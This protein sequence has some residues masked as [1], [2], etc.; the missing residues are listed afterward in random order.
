MKR[1]HLAIS[2]ITR[3]ILAVN[4]VALLILAA[5]LLYLGEYRKGLIASELASLNGQARL[6]AAALGESAVTS[7]DSGQD[8]ISRQHLVKGAVR[9]IVRRLV[10][11]S[12]IRARLFDSG[13]VL[14]ADSRVLMNG[15]GMVQTETL[16]PPAEK[17]GSRFVTALLGLYDRLAGG[18]DLPLYSENQEQ[19]A[20]DYTEASR[21]LTGEG[22]EIVRADGRGGLVLSAAVPVQRY[23][24]VLGALML[25]KGGGDIEAAL[26][27][28]RL[29]ILAV[30][31][32]ALAVT[33]LLS[34]YL[35][36]TI[37]RP[38]HKLAA[39]AEHIRRT[40]GRADAIPPMEGRNDEIGNLAASLR[41]MTEALWQRMDAIERF[42]ADVAHEIKNPLTSLQSAV[43]TA[44]KIE[45]PERQRKLMAIIADDVARLNRLISDIS[46]ASRLDSEL[47]RAKTEP[48]D[49]GEMLTTIAAIFNTRAAPGEPRIEVDCGGGLS[50]MAIGGRLSQVFAN[51][52]ENALSFSPPGGLISIRARG[53]GEIITVTIDDDGPGIAE[54]KEEAIFER[55]YTERPAGEKFGT[56]SGLGLSISKQVIETLGGSI[57]AENR[58][59]EDSEDDGG[60]VIGARF[61]VRLPAA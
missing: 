37:A 43:E 49:L 45:D 40:H 39:A 21:A 11:T 18:D 47:S 2:P 5:G 1:R 15:G 34:L 24:Q 59:S 16:P 41:D 42:A 25:T 60:A 32:V 36:G 57:A 9:R 7:G 33:V 28:V 44:V 8:Q 10:E 13:G 22:A 26:L 19:K 29:S 51:L 48:V 30:F 14:L 27:E 31:G 52:I 17:N 3:R 12:G 58:K 46:D 53:D 6:F 38:L 56:H 35:A 61:R 50:V 54:G 23:K 55:F 4:M 20:A